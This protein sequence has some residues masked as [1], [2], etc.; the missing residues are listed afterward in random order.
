M[1]RLEGDGAR[2]NRKTRATNALHLLLLFS[3]MAPQESL[4]FL[5]LMVFSVYDQI[6]CMHNAQ[7]MRL[8][9]LRG[10]MR[11]LRVFSL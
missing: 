8:M 11:M 1:L 3:K 7:V 9:L 2:S 4:G 5:G 6:A 10:S